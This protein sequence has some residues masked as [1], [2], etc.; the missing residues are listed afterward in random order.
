MADYANMS[1][2]FLNIMLCSAYLLT[3]VEGGSMSKYIPGNQKHL[4][5][6]DR[7]YIEKSLNE[8]LAFKEIARYLCKDPT[9]ISKEIKLHRASYLYRKGSFYNAHNFCVH[10]YRCQRTNV[11]DKIILC[12]IKCTSCTTCNQHCADFVRERCNR[13][14]KAPYV[15]NGCPKTISKCTIPC[16]YRYDAVYA[17]RMYREKLVDSRS[18]INMTKHERNEKDGIISPLVWQ[19]QSPYQIVTNH[20]ELDMSV[21]TLYS[22]LNQGLFRARDIDLKRKVKFKPRKVHKTQIKDRTVFVGRTYA[23]FQELHL[24]H[25]AE[26]DT[27]HSSRESKRVILTFFLTRE[28]LFLAFIMNRC[29]KGAVKLIFNKLEHQ[30]GTYNFLTLFSTILTDRGSEFGDPETL[31]TGMDEIQRSEIYYCDPMRSGQKG[32]IE[33]AHTMLRMVLPKGTSFEFLTQWDLRTI[34]DHINST[35][36]EILGGRTPYDIALENYGPEVLKAL[37][38]RPVDSDEVNLT[39]KLIRFNP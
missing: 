26:M 27:V 9:T 5:L 15:C 19:G 16:K 4:T 1:F 22:Y 6:E 36:R 38:L 29:T 14:D 30:L 24:D 12:G 13:L 34:V 7:K 23:D 11:C 3:A 25:F 33:Q 18:G 31:E 20:P 35:P 17:D 32:G 2:V 10:R 37:Q 28:K 39:P 8:G 21:R